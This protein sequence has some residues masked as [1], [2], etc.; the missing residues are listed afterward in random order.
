MPPPELDHTLLWTSLALLLGGVI[1]VYSATIAT[2][3]GS[4]FA[5]YQPTYFL[6]RHGIFVIIGLLC[7]AVAFQIPVRTWQRLAPWAFSFG[8]LLLIVV[9]IP[10][11]GR[12]VNGAQ[13]WLPLGPVNLQP[14]ELMKLLAVLY[15]A[16]YTVRKLSLMDSSVRRL[17]LK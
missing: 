7:G 10:H 11:V 5:G 12:E 2:A 6:V 4:K 9:L 8:V 16:D 3:E 17:T 14:S 1:M 15:A 13:R